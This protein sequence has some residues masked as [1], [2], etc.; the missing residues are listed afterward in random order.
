M[1]PDPCQPHVVSDDPLHPAAHDA[2]P[3]DDTIDDDSEDTDESSDLE[4]FEGDMLDDANWDVF[5]A[6]DELDPLPEYG[7][8][9]D[10]IDDD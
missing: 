8:F 6:D 5:L 3:A 10:E 1:K 2:E 9:W 7:D 4:C